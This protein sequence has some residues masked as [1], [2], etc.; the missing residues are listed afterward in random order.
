MFALPTV[1]IQ[2]DIDAGEIADTASVLSSS[3][4]PSPQEISARTSCATA[5]P[6]KPEIEIVK[7][8]TDI[9]AASGFDPAVT[10]AGDTFTYVTTVSNTGNTWLSNVAVTDSMFDDGGVDGHGCGS[11]YAEDSSRFAPGE[12]FECTATLTLEQVHVDGRCVESTAKV[13][14]ATASSR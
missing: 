9:T 11:R 12:T 5:L 4:A 3:P 7:N 8:V 2:G 14:C 13:R 1:S 6:R 10:D